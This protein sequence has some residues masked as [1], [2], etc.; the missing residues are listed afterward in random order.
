[1]AMILSAVFWFIRPLFRKRISHIEYDYSRRI[2]PHIGLCLKAN[3][4]RMRTQLV[5]VEFSFWKNP[6]GSESRKRRYLNILQRASWISVFFYNEFHSEAKSM[7]WGG[8]QQGMGDRKHV[9][10]NGHVLA[11][12][13]PLVVC[14]MLVHR[15]ASWFVGD[16]EFDICELC[17]C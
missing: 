6:H 7:A 12:Q 2:D 16:A 3:A 9:L 5:L 17:D 15:L 14:N 10:D 11:S 1:M 13:W 8:R 4:V